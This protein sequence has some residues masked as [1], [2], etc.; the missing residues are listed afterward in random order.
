M[1]S[2][3]ILDN[4]SEGFCR[5]TPNWRLLKANTA[6]LRLVDIKAESPFSEI[7]DADKLSFTFY[8]LGH[9]VAREVENLESV[10]NFELHLAREA[11]DYCWLAVNA[12]RIPD[13]KGQT[14]YYD[15]YIRNIT[16]LKLK[17]AEL[18]HQ[19]FYD[20]LTGLANRELFVD[21]I[22]MAL[23][24]SK[25]RKDIQ[26][27]VLSFDL[28][29]FTNINQHYGR[30]FGNM[31]LRHTAA[32]IRSCCREADTVARTASDEFSVLL[33]GLEDGK[34]IVKIIK[35]VH[36][37]LNAPFSAWEQH[38]NSVRVDI[39]VIFPITDYNKPESVLRD[40]D[41]AVEKAKGTRNQLGCK[42]FSRRQLE[43]TRKHLSLSITLQE[44]HGL[45]DFYLDYQPIVRPV[46]GDLHSF[47]TLVR[48]KHEDTVVPPSIFI[49]IAE[50][51]GFIG[52]LGDFVIEESCR[53]LRCWQ[54][55]Y[56]ANV[57]LHVNISPH[58]LV[59]P[60]FPEKVL[61][62]LYRT[63]I[64]ASRLFF[65]VTESAFL[66]DFEKVLYNI[67]AIRKQGIR[68]CLD[69]FGTGYSSL[70][71][72]K[73]LPIECLKIDRSFINDLE[74]DEKSRILLR[75]ILSIG[76][77]MGYSLVVEGVERQ[78]QL[79]LLGD[80]SRLLIQGYY[81]YR[82]L[83]AVSADTLLEMRLKRGVQ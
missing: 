6:F 72:L 11:G 73:H 56:G 19:T 32:T 61:A 34:Q 16:D 36:A 33:Q 48:W 44:K 60:A 74:R 8:E 23:Q 65:E 47:E 37:K 59:M 52:R 30:G 24:T 58:Q 63:G 76:V 40:V 7:P 77:D 9:A 67:N 81:F 25:R 57:L 38:I 14:S 27:A 26:Y 39:G 50:E 55:R 10:N 80:L 22:H 71:Y 15:A 69:D 12:R 46:G 70:S 54:E 35:R 28:R 17:E 18:S 75:H 68:F 42:F 41:I 43:E 1:P 29:H 82:P 3:D 53:R 5:W 31:L 51:T 79:S 20:H 66:R 21:R 64:D 2:Q 45:E 78:T 62:I 83:S 13:A 49:P 4:F